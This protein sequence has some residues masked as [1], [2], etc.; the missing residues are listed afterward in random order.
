MPGK[1]RSQFDRTLIGMYVEMAIK[2]SIE[3]KCTSLCY[4]THTRG[5]CEI[6]GKVMHVF[7]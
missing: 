5:I 2:T 7:I 1:A 4:S 3:M 6:H